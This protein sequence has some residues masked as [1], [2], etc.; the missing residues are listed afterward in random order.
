M[1]RVGQGCRV[2]RMGSREEADCASATQ[3][4]RALTASTK[5]SHGL[6]SGHARLTKMTRARPCH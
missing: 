4:T 1:N 5:A 2:C 3:T 6:E